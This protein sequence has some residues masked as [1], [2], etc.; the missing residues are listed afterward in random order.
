[1]W[2]PGPCVTI[3]S[4]SSYREVTDH[5]F[6]LEHWLQ[7]MKVPVGRIALYRKSM[8]RLTAV[9]A[10]GKIAE[11]F[12]RDD[13][14][15]TILTFPEIAEFEFIRQHLTP[16]IDRDLP[17]KLATAASG[18]ELTRAENPKRST[19]RPRN[20]LFELTIAATLVS[21][22]FTLE[23]AGDCD[24]RTSFEGRPVLIECKRPQ[25]SNNVERAIKDGMGQ[26]QKR[27]ATGP[28]GRFGILALCVSK[29]LTAGTHV[30]R[31]PTREDIRSE[32]LSAENNFVRRHGLVWIRKAP[33]NVIAVIIHIGAVGI[34]QNQDQLYTGKQYVVH[35]I[36]GRPETEIAL[37]ERFFRQFNSG[38]IRAQTQENQSE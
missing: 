30:I 7:N 17:S 37:A 11:T 20:I 16:E 21:A 3:F 34:A 10:A 32:I 22:G 6:E 25:W 29:V 23:P 15:S 31:V 5:L 1:M 8:E 18:P 36:E 24:L 27:L 4:T 28:A 12:S 19:N 38:T 26:L 14:Q 13:V 9:H 35:P 33:P 2:V